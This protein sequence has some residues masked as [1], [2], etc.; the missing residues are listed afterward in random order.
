MPYGHEQLDIAD[1]DSV[2]E[3]VEREKPDLII[4]CAAWTDVDGC[5]FDPERAFSVNA[6]GPENLARVSKRYNAR[7]ITI[8]TDYVFD[9][10]KDGF[11]TQD[12]VPNPTSVYALSKLEGERRAQSED[13]SAII[14]R[15]GFV[16][17]PRG[18]N[19]L[20]TVVERVRAGA[21]VQVIKDAYGTP[22]YSVDLAKRLRELAQRNHAGIYHVVNAGPGV[23]FEEF[24]REALAIAGLD[25]ANVTSVSM[26]SL[27]RPAA[28]PR[29]S[30]LRCLLSDQLKLEPMPH[31]RTAL[32]EFVQQ[33]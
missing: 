30:R 10:R 12:D 11:Y 21:A 14:V 1:G 23:S 8:S 26:D 31:W 25:D 19:F 17:G 18:R 7:F 13:N 2:L 3:S 22:T 6:G 5:E 32:R 24:A 29:N 4:N 16:F 15:T 9:G 27:D 20:S 28:R 33:K